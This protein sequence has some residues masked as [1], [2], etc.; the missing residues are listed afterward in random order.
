MHHDV[1]LCLAAVLLLVLVP[2]AN[3]ET[4]QAVVCTPDNPGALAGAVREYPLP[5]ASNRPRHTIYFSGVCEGPVVI[6]RQL[7]LVL[8]VQFQG[9][10]L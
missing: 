10:I 7:R 9:R 6:Y 8:D 5:T 2:A 1:V 4:A 3:G